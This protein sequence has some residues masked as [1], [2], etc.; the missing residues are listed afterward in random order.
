MILTN[1]IVTLLYS[2]DW[3]K[4]YIGERLVGEDHSFS[5]AEVLDFLGVTYRKIEIEDEHMLKIAGEYIPLSEAL[6]VKV[7]DS[8][9]DDLLGEIR[10]QQ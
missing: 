3:I 7:E 8:V 4:F 6:A 5:G 10:G 1:E 9:D 2:G